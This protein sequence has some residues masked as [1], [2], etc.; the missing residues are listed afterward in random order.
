MLPAYPAAPAAPQTAARSTC[1]PRWTTP[2]V[3]WLPSARSTAHPARLLAD[4]DLADT[5][6]TADALQTHRDAA[7]VPRGRQTG[8]LNA[9]CEWLRVLVETGHG[10]VS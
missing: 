2:P 5:L 10:Q 4:L 7:W 1:S 3:R 6:V 8:A 9:S